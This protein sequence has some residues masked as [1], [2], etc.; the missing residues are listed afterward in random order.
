M[1]RAACAGVGHAAGDGTVIEQRDPGRAG[2]RVNRDRIQPARLK[3]DRCRIRRDQRRV[4]FNVDRAKI[5]HDRRNDRDV[6]PIDAVGIDS[7]AGQHINLCIGNSRLS[8]AD[9]R[10]LSAQLDR[11]GAEF[12]GRRVISDRIGAEAQ[13][14]HVE[15]RRGPDQD[16]ARA[17]EIDRAAGGRRRRCILQLRQDST[18]ELHRAG[19]IRG[20]DVVENSEIVA[21]AAVVERG[22]GARG[23]EVDSATADGGVVRRPI[24]DCS[25]TIDRHHR[26]VSGGKDAGASGD[27]DRRGCL[28]RLRANTNA[29]GHQ[30]HGDRQH[31]R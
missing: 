4:A 1:H 29:E 31:R 10:D 15:D 26:G 9:P 2:G 20:Q 18:A 16:S 19:G 17:I 23:L 22:G 5:L 14:A 25:R 28:E 24:D 12:P 8:E 13:V 3:G 6:G 11:G 21:A 7:C 27:D 30:R